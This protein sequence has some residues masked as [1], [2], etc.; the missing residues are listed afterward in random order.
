VLKKTISLLIL[1][2]LASGLF[3]MRVGKDVATLPADLEKQVKDGSRNTRFAV[4]AAEIKKGNLVLQNIQKDSLDDIEHRRYRQFFG[5]YAVWGG[6]TIQHVKN[7]V[8]LDYDGEYFVVQKAILVPQITSAQALDAAKIYYA[9]TGLRADKGHTRFYIFPMNGN[10]FHL[11]YQMK[12]TKPDVPL[13]NKTVFI[14]AETGK[15]LLEY[16]NIISEVLTIGTGAG[17]RGDV[18]K[19]PTTLSDAS[20]Y[21]ADLSVAR[22]FSLMTF[23]CL[24]SF[25]PPVYV[26]SSP[27]NSWSSDNVV[28]IHT[29]IGF[30]YDL[31]YRLFGLNG[32]DNKNRALNAYAHVYSVSKELYNNAMWN[33][34]TDLYGQGFYFMDPYRSTK[35][36]GA[37]IDIV[38]H[39]YAHA[40]TTYHSNL[41]YWGESGAL[42]ESFSDII[43]TAVEIMFQPAGQGYNMADWINGEDGNAPFSYSKCRSQSDPNANSQLRNAGFPAAYWYPDP[44]NIRQKVPTITSGGKVIDN[45]NVHINSTIFPH[46]FYLLANGGTNRVSGITVAGIGVEK[47]AKIFYNAWVNHMTASTN[48]LGAANALL[49]SADE[50]YGS[51]TEH[52]RTVETI[53]AIGYVVN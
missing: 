38:A 15:V 18:L 52:D 31:F 19:F 13:F 42:N 39:E 11:A 44:C 47:A 30:A 14:D 17:Q 40:V 16:P 51:G 46:A 43:G 20:Y 45:D 49:R 7:G 26:S 24:H 9:D 35:D 10:V 22:P 32:V 29:Y 34:S 12:I 50:L 5:G 33:P 27:D 41:T 3:A 2:L 8:V 28:N 48:F 21:M 37:A 1:V 36:Y 6:E 25:G 23:N 4:L 53:R